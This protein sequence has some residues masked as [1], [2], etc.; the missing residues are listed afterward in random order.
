M[1]TAA[2]GI[3]AT[4]TGMTRS[5]PL[6]LSDDEIVG[7]P[8]DRLGLVILEDIVENHPGFWSWYNW[9]NAWRNYGLAG[10]E[11][12][13]VIQA[14]GEAWGWL[15]SNGLVADN[16][17]RDSQF[18]TRLGHEV[19]QRGVEFLGAVQ[20]ASS[21]VHPRIEVIVREQFLLGRY[22]LAAF[23]AMREVEIAVREASNADAAALG[24][25]L[26]RRAFSPE[27]GS[28]VDQEAEGGERQGLS[29]LFAG[30]MATFK[31][32]TSHRQI[33]FDEPRRSCGSHCSRK[34]A[35]AHR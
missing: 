34:P 21:D 15:Q 28:L 32:P 3:G 13:P 12:S 31:N 6:S 10:G 26:M 33:T 29:D 22:E 16:G 30:A 7:L 27:T 11:S 19:L 5:R 2:R 24:V 23:A 14:F 25:P 1:S 4:M 18:V 20:R 17:L 8:I 35:P 9:N